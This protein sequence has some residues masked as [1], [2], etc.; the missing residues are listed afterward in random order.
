MR[1]RVGFLGGR[2][3]FSTLPCVLCGFQVARQWAISGFITI[4]FNK[5][6][7]TVIP[8]LNKPATIGRGNFSDIIIIKRNYF[9]VLWKPRS[10]R[11]WSHTYHGVIRSQRWKAELIRKFDFEFENFSFVSALVESRNRKRE[12][13]ILINFIFS[14]CISCVIFNRNPIFN[15]LIRISK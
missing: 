6:F 8:C 2:P 7:R 13:F 5:E 3:S 1:S 15:P 11:H 4:F 14:F 9:S 10:A 12:N